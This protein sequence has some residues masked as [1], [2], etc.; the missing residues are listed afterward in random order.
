MNISFPSFIDIYSGGGNKAANKSRY[1]R[2]LWKSFY[3]LCQ[4]FYQ[5]QNQA[6][7]RKL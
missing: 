1:W 2:K 7:L 6:I 5:V 4:C 3:T